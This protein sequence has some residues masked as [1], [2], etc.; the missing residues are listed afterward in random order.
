MTAASAVL[1]K[2]VRFPEH[3][4]PGCCAGIARVL[5][6]Y[7]GLREFVHIKLLVSSVSFSHN[8]VRLLMVY[9]PCAKFAYS[10]TCCFRD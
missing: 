1:A 4:N 5:C 9:R 8:N 3:V 10:E 2:R 6:R 7:P